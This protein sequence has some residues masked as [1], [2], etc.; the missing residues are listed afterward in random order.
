MEHARNLSEK[1]KANGILIKELTM[2]HKN[3]GDE[4][5]TVK[6]TVTV[7]LTVTATLI[8]HELQCIALACVGQRKVTFMAVH[9]LKLEL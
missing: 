7:T 4:T 2:F 1:A 8:V 6:V 5:V 9:K 3:K